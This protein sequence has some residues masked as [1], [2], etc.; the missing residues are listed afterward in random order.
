MAGSA[1]TRVRERAVYSN[2]YLTLFDDDVCF[3]SGAV[4]KYVR[5][6][7]RAACGVAIVA[8]NAHGQYLLLRCFN[9]A[10]GQWSLQVPKGFGSIERSP[11]EQA[12]AELLEETGH[13]SDAWRKI[14]ELHVDPG[15]VENPTLVFEALRT[16]KV[17]PACPEP[18]EVLGECFW[19]AREE[20][21]RGPFLERI[22]DALTRAVLLAHALACG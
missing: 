4:G 13:A 16:R 20:L 9:Y 15:F 6:Q 19:V 2:E 1:I 5:A 7:W 8:V 22:D 21:M 3:P 12:R 11:E 18:T 14:A 17:A 10:T